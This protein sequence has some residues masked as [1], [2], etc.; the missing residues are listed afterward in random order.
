MNRDISAILEN[1]N[2]FIQVLMGPR[3]CGKSSLY[4]HLSPDYIELSMDDLMLR[5]QI[6]LNPSGFIDQFQGKKILIDEAQLCPA[7]FPALKRSVDLL[8]RKNAKKETIFRLTG[9]NHIMLDKNVKESLA[10]RASYYELNTLSVSEILSSRQ[11]PC[12]D[13]ILRGGW[14]E[15]Y[16]DLTLSPKK[17][18][19]DYIRSY[20]EKDII[21]SAGIQ[22]QREFLLLI[23]LLAA[24]TAQ[25]LN[26][27]DLSK[28]LGLSSE[29]VKKWVSILERMKIVSLVQPFSNN[30]SKRL[31]KSSKIYF[32][33][34]G[35][36]S[37]LQG[38][39]ESLP[40]LSSTYIGPLFETLVYCEL[41]KTIINFDLPVKIFHYRTRDGEEID[42][43]LEIAATK[44]LMIE[45]KK[46]PLAKNSRRYPE[47]RKIF[48][49]HLPHMVTC[50]M[51]DGPLTKD[52]VPIKE[53]K[54]YILKFLGHEEL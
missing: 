50:Q 29:T 19:D 18:L 48:K 41:Y 11:I 36:A 14:P 5:Q 47:L 8:K 21:L 28:V 27:S 6:E 34:V 2:Q 39:Y 12:I 31:V 16:Q 23:Q 10:G 54:N 38:H 3:Q 22:K 17:F 13:I 52:L 49:A 7:L 1:K 35:L 46:S 32:L 30:L 25:E 4:L 44:Y 15:L 37:R 51:S 45:V 33:D 40:L 24:R 20:V 26:Y 53:L 43:L 9:S 42:F